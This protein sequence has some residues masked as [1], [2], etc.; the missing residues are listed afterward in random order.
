MGWGIPDQAMS[1]LTNF[2]LNIYVARELGAVSY[3]AFALAYVTYAFALNASRGLASDPLMV[4]YSATD[5][6]TWRRAAASCTGTA[7]VTGLVLGVILLAITPLLGG[8]AQMAFLALGLSMPGLL[9]QDS[10]RFAFFAQARGALA[11]INDT[12][13]AVSLVAGLAVLRATGHETVFWAVLVWGASASVGAALG[14]FQARVKPKLGAARQ[15]LSRNW[16]LAPRYVIEGTTNSAANQVA[17]YSVGLLLG[18]AAV[19]AVTAASILLGPV[20]MIVYGMGLV[21]IPEGVRI[22]KTSPH[23]LPHACVLTSAALS[24]IAAVWGIVLLVAL[25]L[26]L[27][28]TLF[29]ASLWGRTSPLVL[30]TVLYGIAIGVMAG[31][32]LGLHALAAARRSLRAAI[33]TSLMYVAFTAIGAAASGTVAAVSGGAAAMWIGAAVF[34][35]ELRSALREPLP[36]PVEVAT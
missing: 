2:A 23:R 12:V 4:R 28:Q 7:A 1:S 13:W 17:T 3:G 20:M 26:G 34:W 10:W 15:W 8:S 36:V 24:G 29:G 22:L 11:L 33:I 21:L 16:D 30:P 27:G 25:P 14:P 32:G 19:G 18:L 31:A 6:P 5:Q 9:L 35:W